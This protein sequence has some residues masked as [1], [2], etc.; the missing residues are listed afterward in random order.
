MNTRLMVGAVVVAASSVAA[1]GQVDVDGVIGTEWTGA[2]VNTVTYNSAA[3]TSNFGAPTNETV[4]AA[5]NTY[6]R[7]DAGWVYFA[8]ATNGTGGTSAG[9]F[10]NLY[11]SSNNAGSGIGMQVTGDTFF[12]PSTSQPFANSSLPVGQR[13][14]WD[15]TPGVIELAIP[16]SFF[17]NDPLGM[18]FATT[19]NGG[20]VRWNLSQSFGYSVAG[21]Q[22]FYGDDRLGAGVIP[23]PGAGMIAF[24]GMAIA[25]GRRRRA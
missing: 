7:I 19:P 9:N 11:I 2:Q 18:N 15:E 4:G 3:P 16:F 12:I 14:V 6:F 1:F 8:V 22:S 20:T 24:A 10:A 25:A 17:Q 21:G 13:A 5:Y 23:V